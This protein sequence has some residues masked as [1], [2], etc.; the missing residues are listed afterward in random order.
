MAKN[1]PNKPDEVKAEPAKDN[2]TKEKTATAAKPLEVSGDNAVT[3]PAAKETAKVHEDNKEPPTTP[4]KSDVAADTVIPFS[5]IASAEQTVKS[6]ENPAKETKA[7]KAPAPEQKTARRGRPS[8][9]DKAVKEPKPDKAEKAA[10]PPKA[11]KAVK[12]PKSTAPKEKAPPAPEQPPEPKEAPRKGEQEQIVYLNLSELYAFKDHPFE[13]K[14]DAEMRAMVES[15]KDIENCAEIPTT[16][17]KANMFMSIN[18]ANELSP[19][20]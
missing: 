17:L 14:N 11:E 20:I 1:E 8:K 5:K 7:P 18:L 19:I 13:V 9:A 16:K 3:E 4:P 10:K 2:S 6:A 15:V 12:P